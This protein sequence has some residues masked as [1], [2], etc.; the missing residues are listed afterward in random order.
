MSTISLVHIKLTHLLKEKQ[1]LQQ[2]LLRRLLDQDTFRKM[3][4]WILLHEGDTTKE[5]REKHFEKL[6]RLTRESQRRQPDTKRIVHNYSNRKL[7]KVE[8]EVLAL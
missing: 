5:N 4:S 1:S 8:E 7:D 3:E 2:E 6:D